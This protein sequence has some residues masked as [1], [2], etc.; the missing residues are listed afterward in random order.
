MCNKRKKQER[1]STEE[2]FTGG[3][4]REGTPCS[5]QLYV[6]DVGRFGVSQLDMCSEGTSSNIFVVTDHYGSVLFVS[7]TFLKANARALSVL[8][9][10]FT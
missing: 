10:D 5:V 3:T 4:D 9:C 7:P 6:T 8:N 1:C 2:Y